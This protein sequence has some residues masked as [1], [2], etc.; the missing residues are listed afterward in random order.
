MAEPDPKADLCHYL[1]DA[2]DA[3]LW[4]LEG[5]SGYDIRRPLV[6]TGTNLLGL[7][8]HLAGVEM[9]YFGGT[10]GAPQMPHQ[11][12]HQPRGGGSGRA[13]A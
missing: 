3:L 7:V 4:K 9:G 6:A 13:R 8:K 2:R 5:L 10:F 1:K 12:P 11:Q